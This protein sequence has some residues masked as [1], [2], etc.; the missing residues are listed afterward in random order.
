MRKLIK[1][2][3]LGPTNTRG[4][5]V[6]IKDL[7]RKKK[8]IIPYD[9]SKTNIIDMAIEYLA[10]KN[11]INKNEIEELLTYCNNY[12]LVVDINVNL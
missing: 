9:Y 6:S 3:Y 12:Y 8:K 1:V 10:D 4:S 2:N 7:L 5:R 11:K